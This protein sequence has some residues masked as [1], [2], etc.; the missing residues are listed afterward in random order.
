M[1]VVFTSNYDGGTLGQDM[2][3]GPGA[4]LSAGYDF[5]VGTLKPTFQAGLIGTL[6]QRSQTAGTASSPSMTKMM[7]GS[8]LTYIACIRF[9]VLMTTAVTFYSLQL[10][11]SAAI[12][13]VLVINNTGTVRMRS[14]AA[15][16]GTALGAINGTTPTRVE[17]LVTQTTQ[18]CR[19][20][21]GDQLHSTDTTP[22]ANFYDTGSIAWTPAGTFD[23]LSLGIVSTTANVTV[24]HDKVAIEDTATWI[25]PVI[26]NT[27]PTC[28]AGTDQ[29]GI[30]PGAPIN[31]S[32]TD[33][34]AESNITTREWL[35]GG[36]VVGT[37]TTYSTTARATFA[38]YTDTYTYRVTDSGGLQG[39]DTVDVTVLPAMR[40]LMTAGGLKPVVSIGA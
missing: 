3:N 11:T 39:A 37:G 14:N 22:R 10:Q 13:A 28:N 23:R 36:I 7:P 24:F 6:S 38:G 33:N 4:A 34:D 16:L 25:G 12:R 17:W 8:A 18:Q 35:K 26:T 2:V 40:H 29:T 20:W 1:A 15:N 19:L 31:L 27:A 30:E 21:G 9:Y 5:A 32:A